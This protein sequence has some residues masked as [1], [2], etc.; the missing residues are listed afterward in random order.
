MLLCTRQY[1]FHCVSTFVRPVR[2]RSVNRTDAGPGGRI[3][4]EVFG[5]VGLDLLLGG[6]LVV[7]WIG[8]LPVPGLLGDAFIT[9]AHAAVGDQ[10]RDVGFRQGFE[11]GFRVVAGVGGDR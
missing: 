5:A 11:I 4:A 1:N 8:L 10:R 9:L 3:E 6:R 2:P 7:Q